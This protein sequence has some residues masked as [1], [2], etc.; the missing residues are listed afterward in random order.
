MLIEKLKE[1]CVSNSWAFNYGR[2][3]W[4]NNKDHQ[5]DTEE[6]FEDKSKHFL[7]LWKDRA[8]KLDQYSTVTGYV[9][10]GE[11]VFCVKTR[12]DEE[13]YNVQYDK[14]ISKLEVEVAKLFESFTSCNGWKVDSWKETEVEA[15][16]DSNLGGLKIR[17]KMTY[18]E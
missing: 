14:Y 3:H 1:I 18:E 11:F 10:E 17:F 2:N 15:Q 16:Y 8:F 9:F 13:D 12:L 4:Q 6:D 5:D 7:L